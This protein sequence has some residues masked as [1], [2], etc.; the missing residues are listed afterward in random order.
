MKKE[1]SNKDFFD[2]LVKEL[3]DNGAVR[4]RVKGTSM[5][6]LLRSEKDEVLLRSP[7]EKTPKKGSIVLFKYKDSFVLHRL[8]KISDDVLTFRGDNVFACTETCTKED[9]TAEVVRIFRLKKNGKYVSLPPV[10]FFLKLIIPV[11]R[12]LKKLLNR[13]HCLK[14]VLTLKKVKAK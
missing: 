7:G 12:I 5:L 6:P 2:L 11:Y 4:I 1:F 8:I 9:I 3:Q 14:S 13:L 10:S